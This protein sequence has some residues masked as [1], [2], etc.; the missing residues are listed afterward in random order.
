M[1]ETTRTDPQP[2]AL[3]IRR[4]PLD[5]LHLDPANARAHG[6]RNLEAIEGSLVRFGQAEP[7]VVHRETGRVIAGNGRLVAM[8]KLGWSECD[9]VEV[10][11]DA[12]EATA[13]G[14]ALNRTA[15]L[16]SWDEPALAKLLDGLRAEDALAGVGFTDID[17]DELLAGLEAEVESELDDPGPEEP[18]DDPV[19]HAGDLWVMG[20]HRLLC[21]DSRS[22]EGYARLLENHHADLVWTDPPY[23]VSYEGKA[24][25]IQ[26][27][28]AEGLRE[29]LRQSLGTAIKHTKVGAPWYVAAPAGPQFL[30]FAQVLTD[31]CVWRQTLVWVKNSLVL[32]HSDFH[33]RHEALFY[34]WTPG[35]K[36]VQPPDR[37]QDTIWLFDRP[38]HSPDHPTMKP[39]EL[40]AHALRL[41]SKKDALVLDLF[42]GSGTT[43]VACEQLGRRCR[44]FEIDPRYVD[45]ALRRWEQITGT[46]AVLEGDGRPF[47][48]VAEER[49]GS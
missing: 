2:T 28:S 35:G 32:G 43:L 29:L 41:S 49:T 33:Y 19:S 44:G 39:V 9:V 3:A 24:G 5:S 40:V 12:I 46:R 26:N 31:L 37:S 6:E 15:D 25:E 27:D 18:L 16:A 20:E 23:G 45:V 1:A 8:R 4:V 48:Q 47:A 21:A 42:L 13:L 17:I 10:G 14:I 36:H 7:L 30:D 34:G 11:L 38:S 22:P